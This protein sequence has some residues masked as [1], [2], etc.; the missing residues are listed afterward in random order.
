[1]CIGLLNEFIFARGLDNLEMSYVSIRSLIDSC[2]DTKAFGADQQIRL[3]ALFDNEEVG[4]ASQYGAA[5]NM[6]SQGMCGCAAA[7]ACCCLL[8]C[9]A[10]T[11]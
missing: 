8:L 1:M 2:A 5:S 11:D 9:A 6:M 7:A 10:V 3:V 4:S